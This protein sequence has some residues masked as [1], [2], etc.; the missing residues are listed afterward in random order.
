MIS[1]YNFENCTPIVL[2]CINDNEGLSSL[3]SSHDL[4]IS[5]LPYVFHP[6]VCEK[7]INAGKQ[8]VTA[9]YLSDGMAA[10]DEKAKAA[11]ITVMNEVGV[12]P[13]IDHMLAMELFDELKEN[14]ED[15]QERFEIQALFE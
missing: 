5:L 12:D 4:T 14:G 1:Q 8:M 3:I 9:S 2:D 6:H 7:V 15:V 11:G 13:G 10:L